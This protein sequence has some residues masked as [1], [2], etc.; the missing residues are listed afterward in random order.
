MIKPTP[1]RVV[2]YYPVADG[3]LVAIDGPEKPLAALIAHVHSDTLVNLSVIDS[4]GNSHGRCEIVLVQDGGEAAP[5]GRY[6]TWMPYQL[7]QAAR[8]QA[9]EAISG[10]GQNKPADNEKAAD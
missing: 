6:C 5:K 9:A 10:E 7:G 4:N 2:W 3:A 8:T 1:G